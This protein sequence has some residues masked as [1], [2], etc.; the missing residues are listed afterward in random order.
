[1]NHSLPSLVLTPEGCR[2]PLQSELSIPSA[3]PKAV[4]VMAAIFPSA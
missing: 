4:L 1:V 2:P 3:L